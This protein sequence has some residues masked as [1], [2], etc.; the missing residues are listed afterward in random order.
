MQLFS[1]IFI[2]LLLA[3]SSSSAISAPFEEDVDY[4][5]I[6]QPQ[7][8]KS[9]NKIEVIE[10]FWYGC[11]HCNN[12]DPYLQRWK[13]G[14]A[15]DVEVVLIPAIF[16]PEWEIHARAFYTAQVLKVLDKIHPAM[17][18]AIHDRGV[19]MSNEAQ[20][21]KLFIDNGVSER[22]FKRI[23]NSFAVES[24]V[25]KAKTVHTNYGVRSVPNMVING[26]YRTNA[27][28]AG[29]NV[30]VLKVADYL[31]SQERKK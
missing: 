3:F 14:L 2:S 9:K 30:N 23:F 15:S 16:R 26:T 27:G 19:P 7:P 10:F 4:E 11:P 17:F 13:K 18:N 8:T 6:D 5:R 29:N 22:N 28:L 21:M 24:K 25:R 1:I 12:F 20:I 31:I